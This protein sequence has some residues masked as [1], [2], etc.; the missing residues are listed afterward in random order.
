MNGGQCN[1]DGPLTD[2]ELEE[3]KKIRRKIRKDNERKLRKNQKDYYV[4]EPD[5]IGDYKD[6]YIAFSDGRVIGCAE[7]SHGLS[8]VI[9][10]DTTI[11]TIQVGADSH[12]RSV[13]EEWEKKKH[14]FGITDDIRNTTLYKLNFQSDD[15][16]DDDDSMEDEVNSDHK[17]HAN[18]EWEKKKHLFGVTDDIRNTTLW[19]LNFQSSDD[20]EDDAAQIKN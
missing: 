6:K 12:R 10:D 16:D 1:F 5:I 2:K 15:D 14:L 4:S 8:E 13:N 18:E 9:G 19:K 7:T 20:D 17:R 3:R 11:F